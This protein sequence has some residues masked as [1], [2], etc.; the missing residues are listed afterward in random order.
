MSTP[1][2][3]EP[4]IKSYFF[5]KGYQD[6]SATITESWKRNLASSQEHFDK[7]ARLFPGGEAGKALAILWGTAGV[8]VVIFG[9]V[10]FLVASAVH[11]TILFSFFLLIYLGFSLVYLTERAYLAG[12]Q[13]F[14]VCPECHAKSRLP[15]HFCPRCGEVHRRLIPSSYGILHHTCQCGEKLPATFFLKRGL[16]KSRCPDCLSLLE[17]AHTESRKAFVPVF[18]GPGVGK[19]AFLFSAVSQLIDQAPRSGLQPSFLESRTESEMARVR[20]QL[21]QGRSPDK[22]LST[23]P[24]AFNLQIQA[25]GRDPRVL[26]LYDPA[27]EAFNETEGLVLHRYQAYL[28]GLIFLIDPFTIPAVCE[29]YADR[30]E[31]VRDALKPS[32]LPVEDALARILIS[33]EEH[34]GLGK[35]TRLKVPVAV[36]INKIDAFDLESRIGE[37]VVRQRVQSSPDPVDPQSVRDEILRGQLRRWGQGDVV[38]QLETRCAR[39]RYFTCSALGHMPDESARAFEARGVLEPLLWILCETDPVFATERKKAA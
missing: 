33:M 15:E 27:G 1:I 18:G 22:T 6:L 21:A 12:K 10:V 39:V 29:E 5:G 11:I 17:T 16:L 38:Q 31:S 14:T 24:R 23:L 32:T 3:P 13:F 2:P 35:A 19:S 20:E 9:T 28:S 30:L 36:V 26:Y 37:P 4:A 34:F 8:S 7:A 25:A